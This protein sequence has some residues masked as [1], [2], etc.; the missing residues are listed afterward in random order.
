MKKNNIV[1]VF[2]HEKDTA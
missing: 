2:Q 1:E